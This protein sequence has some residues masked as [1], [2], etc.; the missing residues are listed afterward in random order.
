MVNAFYNIIENSIEF[1]AGI[2]QGAF[3]SSDRP[4]YAYNIFV[5][6]V[7]D[8]I[9]CLF[10]IIWLFSYLNFGAIGF[11]IGHE[12]THGFD[13]KGLFFL[14]KFNMLRINNVFVLL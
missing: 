4:K 1:P 7:D 3:F 5:M 11:V 8:K 12:I 9:V 6:N 13:D 14:F 10:V 2:L